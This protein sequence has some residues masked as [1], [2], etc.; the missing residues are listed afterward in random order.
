MKKAF[1]NQPLGLGDIF[2]LQKAV[3]KLSEN[4]DEFYY[5]VNDNVS[6]I[7]DYLIAP[8]CILLTESEFIKDDSYDCIDL[9]HTFS[10]F[11]GGIMKSKYNSLGIDYSD[12]QNYFNF[13]RN[14]Q[15]EKELKDLLKIKTGEK[16]AVVSNKWGSYPMT[17]NTKKINFTTSLRVINVDFI[18][19][20][21][22]FDWCGIFED[23]TEIYMI[24]TCFN[25]ILEKIDLSD[26][27][28]FLW[29]RHVIPNFWEFD[30]VFKKPWLKI[31]N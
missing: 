3:K 25:Y 5:P 16:Y 26:K 29:S 8:Y 14:Y 7:K 4:Y 30:G 19:G 6:F 1:I 20:Y 31:Q 21:N 15:K 17:V 13:K 18:E 10:H 22:V 24:E 27:H 2:F 23:A 12:W 9:N 28:L 11:P